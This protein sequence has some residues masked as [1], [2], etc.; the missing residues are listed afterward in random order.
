MIILDTN[1]LSETQRLRPNPGVMAWL[2]SQ[3]PETLWLTAITVAEIRYGIAAL[4][5]GSR[6]R[7]LAERFEVIT[8]QDFSDRIISL[9]SQAAVAFG[10]RMAVARRSG[11]AVG[12]ADGMIA[13]IAASCGAAV[14]T[15]DAGPFEAMGIQVVNPW[16]QAR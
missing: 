15:R 6:A 1:V 12:L 2:D 11:H 9:D 3:A 8:T 5:D 13:A 16:D 14:A 4:P 7:L 10:D